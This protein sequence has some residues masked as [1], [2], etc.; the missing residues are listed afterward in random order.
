MYDQID[1]PYFKRFTE[2]KLFPKENTQT[3]YIDQ[4]PKEKLIEHK[5]KKEEGVSLYFIPKFR[6][7]EFNDEV[8][9][10]LKAFISNRT[11]NDLINLMIV[12]PNC[13][14]QTETYGSKNVSSEGKIKMVESINKNRIRS[15][16][17]AG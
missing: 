7:D 11:N 4:I 15:Y 5:D 3:V 1:F 8:V 6:L 12:C 17:S 13:H 2:K 9:D 16:S 10:N 14:S